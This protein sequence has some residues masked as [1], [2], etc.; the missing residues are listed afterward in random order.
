MPQLATYFNLYIPLLCCV[1]LKSRSQK[2]LTSCE[3][4]SDTYLCCCRNQVRI[5]CITRFFFV[6]VMLRHHVSSFNPRKPGLGPSSRFRR[7][8]FCF[9]EVA[10]RKSVR[11]PQMI[12]L[13]DL[14]SITRYSRWF[15]PG[16]HKHLSSECSY[17]TFMR[18]RVTRT[19]PAPITRIAPMM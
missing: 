5:G 7:L 2:K 13:G 6:P 17:W 1:A 10:C 12:C 8:L 15:G 18:R 9:G 4:S 11:W 19:T 3:I 16:A 14:V